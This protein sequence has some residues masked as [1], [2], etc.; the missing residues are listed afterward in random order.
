MLLPL[1]S[2]NTISSGMSILI[3]VLTLKRN[4]MTLVC[5]RRMADSCLLSGL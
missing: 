5:F 1:V 3:L 4:A 2:F